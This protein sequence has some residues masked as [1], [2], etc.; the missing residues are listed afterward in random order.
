MP[1]LLCTL[2]SPILLLISVPLALFAFL[3]TTF[4]FSTLFFRVLV[5]Y[6][7]L[8]VVLVHDQ[9]A[10]QPTSRNTQSPLK[11]SS[12]VLVEKEHR[13]RSRRSS[14]GSGNSGS[15]TPRI[16][17][18]S[19]LGIYGGGGIGRDFEGVGG[20]RFPDHGHE[21]VLWTSM[22]SRLELPATVDD[23]NRHHRRS[24]T[25]GSLSSIPLVTRSPVRS[26]A[27]TPN[28][29][30]APGHVSPE[31]YFV[32]RPPSRSITA[33]DTANIGKSLLRSKT[34]SISTFSLDSHSRSMQSRASHS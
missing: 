32:D 20:W 8:G 14:V 11:A 13:R 29:S 30:R 15:H 6:A 33:L 9:F 21:D 17:E 3:T 4:A 22:N 12:P 2:L 16:P 5:V 31:E 25:S 10:S 26:R 19:G 24:L 28:S 34:S 1:N 7:E 23:R 27:R 18:S